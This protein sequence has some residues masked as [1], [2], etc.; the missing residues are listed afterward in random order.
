[1]AEFTVGCTEAVQKGGLRH[2]D[3]WIVDYDSTRIWSEPGSPM[4]LDPGIFRVGRVYLSHST[5][6]SK[7][8]VSD[9]LSHFSK[10]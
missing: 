3:Y 8:M 9:Y 5:F 4:P 6:S 10:L 7:S 2:K 1:M